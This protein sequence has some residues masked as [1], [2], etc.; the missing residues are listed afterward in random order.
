MN[1][2]NIVFSLAV[3]AGAA[4]SS[5]DNEGEFDSFGGNETLASE[6]ADGFGLSQPESDAILA[7]VNTASFEVLDDDVALDVRAARHIVEA[8]EQG[9]IGSLDELDDIPWVGSRALGKLREYVHANGLVVTAP[10]DATCLIISEYVEGKL[11]DNKAVE[12]WNCGASEV[13]LD[14]VALCLI[15]N[16][17]EDCTRATALGRRTLAP[18][19]TI[20]ACRALYGNS[21]NDPVAWITERCDLEV[22]A[23][24][25]FSGDD[26]LALV[27]DTNNDAS[28][29]L[30]EDEI[31]DVLGRIGYR[32]PASPWKDV[33]LDRCRLQPN[34]GKTFYRTDEWFH[35][36]PWSSNGGAHLGQAPTRTS[37]ND[38]LPS[39]SR[40]RARHRRPARPSPR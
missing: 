28:F 15:R 12:I 23:T 3:I 37:C 8:R 11:N 17:D 32:P 36:E 5:T 16:D 40:C 38:P 13:A 6:R 39:P 35:S 30:A 24:A 1:V 26:R 25:I 19:D 21:F 2:R 33:R 20:V 7:L 34:D 14:D 18:D 4:C 10:H 31:L 29:T 27:R 22:G 9:P